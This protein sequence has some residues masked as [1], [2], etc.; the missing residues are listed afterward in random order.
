MTASGR[1]L[2]TADTSVSN[3]GIPVLAHRPLPPRPPRA[4]PAT[5]DR[6]MPAHTFLPRAAALAAAL[7]LFAPS[8]G[9]QLM[10]QV[11][12]EEP[13]FETAAIYAGPRIWIGNLNGATAIGVQAERGM[14]EPGT[15]GPGIISAGAGVDY[16][17]WS[18]SYTGLGRYSYSVIP[19]QIFSNYHFVLE[20]YPR[21][22]PYLGLA[23]VYQMVSSSW[24]GS[25]I[26][27]VSASGSSTDIAGQAGVRYF[28]SPTLAAQAQVGFG[29]GTLGLGATWRF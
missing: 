24:D 5:N 10:A 22:D 11:A 27:G 9:D 6:I 26:A 21:L 8:A 18:Q 2:R 7:I 4:P 19:I 12:P 17:S 23:L 14:T 3:R 13:H 15:Y 20:D 25:G 16:Y 29:Y 1:F 28:F